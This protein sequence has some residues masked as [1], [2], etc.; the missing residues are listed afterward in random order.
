[1]CLFEFY[2][3]STFVGYLIPNPFLDKQTVLYIFS[4]FSR[5]IILRIELQWPEN[6][7]NIYAW[8]TE[9]LDSCF[10]LIRSQQQ[11]IL[12]PPPPEIEPATTDCRAEILQLSQQFISHT[13]NT[14]LTKHGSISSGV[15]H[16]ICYWW[17]L[18]RLKQ[19]SSIPVCRA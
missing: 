3:I 6:L 2:G 4:F 11:C 13:N 18:I 10:D 14:K 19:L 5:E 9:T 17:D 15:D 8:H 16:G 12:W 7:A 1:M